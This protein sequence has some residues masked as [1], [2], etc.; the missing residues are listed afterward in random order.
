MYIDPKNP[1]DFDVLAK[2]YEDTIVNGK[3]THFKKLLKETKISVD[4]LADNL[5]M[6][7]S[8]HLIY[9]ETK[10][11][12]KGSI[13]WLHLHTRKSNANCPKHIQTVCW[14][15]K[16]TDCRRFVQSCKIKNSV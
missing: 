9:Y 2:I 14:K 1:K 8:L 13:A 3:D 16:S 12:K 11:N 6:L 10:K 4:V 15:R 5:N 7:N